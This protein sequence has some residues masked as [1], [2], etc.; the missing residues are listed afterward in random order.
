[1]K[2]SYLLLTGGLAFVIALL[3]QAPAALIYAWT[4]ASQPDAPVRLHGVDGSVLSGR[5]R[6]V[7]LGPQSVLTQLRWTARPADLLLGRAA[8]H[9]TADGPPTLLDGIVV[10]G[11]GG[12]QVSALKASG[13]LRAIAATFGQAF[14]PMSG[15]IGLQIDRLRMSD[16]WPA[17]AEGEI[18]VSGLAWTLGREPVALGDFRAKITTAADDIVATI[19]TAAGVVDVSG[20]GRLKADRQ[21]QLAL[22]LK[23]RTGA[24]EFVEALLRQL[25]PSNSQGQYALNLPNGPSTKAAFETLPQTTPS[26]TEEATGMLPLGVRSIPPPAEHRNSAEPKSLE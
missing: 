26:A 25:G 3:V 6:Q 7:S 2:P 16:N 9:V 8:F 20:D 14:V 22:L 11:L 15:Q 19:S 1:M 10:I 23:P 12:T 21:Y 4:L 18:R 5:A 13:D 17:Q 24:P